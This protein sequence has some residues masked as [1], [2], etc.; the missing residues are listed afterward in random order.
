MPLPITIF[1]DFSLERKSRYQR[2]E[3]EDRPAG[4]DFHIGKGSLKQSFADVLPFLVR[5]TRIS[6]CLMPTN[7]A[8]VETEIRHLVEEGSIAKARNELANIPSGASLALDKWKRILAK[9]KGK[10][11]GTTSGSRLKPNLVWLR[12]N[13]NQY[14]GQWVA[15]REGALLGNHVSRT[16][17]R[18][19]LKR[20]DQL[21]GAL[22]F[23][24]EE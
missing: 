4:K 8:Q 23:K 10:L 14:K 11:E 21:R 1:S 7:F 24:V 3:C 19:N 20:L 12:N 13:S 16:A 18:A 6:I 9:P 2:L 17:L 22:F 15:L 5:E